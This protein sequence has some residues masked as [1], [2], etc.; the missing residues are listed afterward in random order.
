MRLGLFG[1]KFNPVHLGHLVAAQTAAE[2]LA[3]DRLV[4]VPVGRP[5]RKD[6]PELADG[7]ARLA[8][9]RLAVGDNPLYDVSDVEIARPGKSMTIDTVRHFRAAYPDAE[10]TFLL[11]SDVIDRLHQW[12][13]IDELRRLCRF[14]VLLRAGQDRPEVEP[15]IPRLRVPAIDISST[16]LRARR[17]KHQ[18]IDFLTPPP[19]ADYIESHALYT[20]AALLQQVQAVLGEIGPRVVCCSGGVDSMLLATIA[21]RL[22]PADTVV[23]HAISPAVPD[24]ATGRVRSWGN[25]EG[26]R[27]E[28]VTSNEFTDERYLANPVNRCYF[29]KSHLYDTLKVIAA[30]MPRGAVMLSGANTD[31]LGEYRPGLTAAAEYNVRH[32]FVETGIDK[33]AIRA[34]AAHLELPFADLP[35]APCLASRVYTGTRVTPAR[36]RAIEEAERAIREATGVKV[37]RAR[38]RENQMIVEMLESERERGSAAV[39][40]EALRRAQSAEPGIAGIVLDPEPYRPGRAFIGE[41]R[42]DQL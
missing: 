2:A 10:I 26:W 28:L 4:F 42:D 22:A 14:A 12:Q 41:H 18:A 39:L 27:L 30:G 29:C 8:M 25:Q 17:L 24:E 13:E 6:S 36:M 40:A 23:A 19:V 15:E 9:L 5:M 37:V 34:I 33:A 32:P 31:D 16:V 21:H 7:T 1:G 38:V 11:G 35:A 3:F 20:P